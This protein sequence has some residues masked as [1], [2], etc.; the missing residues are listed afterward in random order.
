M[1]LCRAGEAAA[2]HHAQV[3]G[4]EEQA[5]DAQGALSRL[6]REA[7]A[8]VA[9][10]IGMWGHTA[11][12]QMGGQARGLEPWPM[13]SPMGGLPCPSPLHGQPSMVWSPALPGRHSSPKHR[14]G[15]QA[16]E[17]SRG[18]LGSRRGPSAA[19]SPL[20]MAAAKAPPHARVWACWD[21]PLA[22]MGP[23]VSLS[24]TGQDVWPALH[25]ST[26]EP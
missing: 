26:C 25:G 2:A 23:H 8:E 3:K 5:A 6:H 1:V 7:K 22:C 18:G 10:C 17:A 16:L 11:R 9:R 24:L 4:L 13:A 19:V 12:D 15:T 14:A 21:G 20:M